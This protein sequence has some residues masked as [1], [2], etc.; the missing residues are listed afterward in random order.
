MAK[1]HAKGELRF[2]VDIDRNDADLMERLKG[3]KGNKGDSIKG[4]KGD[5]IV[6]PVSTEPGPKGDDGESIKGDKGDKG[7]DSMEPGPRGYKGNEPSDERI[8]RLIRKVLAS[9][10][11]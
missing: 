3:D 2:L 10:G 8:E 9:L 1:D 5:S 11:G 7:D 6:G 4:D